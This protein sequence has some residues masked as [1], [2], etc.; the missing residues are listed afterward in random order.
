MLLGSFKKYYDSSTATVT[1]S[2]S[3]FSELFQIKTGVKQ[4]G[5]LSP[6]LFNIFIDDLIEECLE[7]N[8]G[9]L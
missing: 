4:G 5:I 1:T 3:S 7:K 8:I 2:K 6:F 9:A